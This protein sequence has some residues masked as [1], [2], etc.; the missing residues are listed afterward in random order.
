MGYVLT[1]TSRWYKISQHATASKQQRGLI[2]LTTLSA[3][4]NS[5]V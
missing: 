2:D 5:E 1:H 3:R 4:A